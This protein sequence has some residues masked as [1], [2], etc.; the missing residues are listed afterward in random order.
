MKT[1]RLHITGA[2]RRISLTAE[3]ASID[4]FVGC[5][6]EQRKLRDEFLNH[7]IGLDRAAVTL[8]VGWLQE[9]LNDEA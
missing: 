7:Y 2:L 8:L 3:S 5:D 9:W 6:T 1:K 4:I